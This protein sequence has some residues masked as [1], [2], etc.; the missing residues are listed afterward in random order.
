MSDRLSQITAA[1]STA[2]CSNAGE[3]SA[4]SAGDMQTQPRKG[5]KKSMESSQM[6][7]KLSPTFALGTVTVV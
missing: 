1:A 3:A 7:G 4:S 2:L 6:L 5:K